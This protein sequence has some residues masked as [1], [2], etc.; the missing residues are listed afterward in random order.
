[1]DLI[2]EALGPLELE[3][4]DHHLDASNPIFHQEEAAIDQ[5]TTEEKTWYPFLN[6]EVVRVLYLTKQ[7]ES[8][9]LLAFFL[10]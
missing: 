2:D 4:E 1:M 7:K 6:K 3:P 9:D 10:F 5:I 8:K